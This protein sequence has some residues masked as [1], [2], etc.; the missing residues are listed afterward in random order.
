MSEIC[1]K[2]GLPKELCMC[3]EIAREQQSVRIS[4]DSRRYGKT[5][6]VIDG[7][8]GNDIDIADL[9]KTLKSRCAAGGTCKDGR[10]ELQGDHKKKV[11][12]VLEEIGFRTEVR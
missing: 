6:T 2:C 8:D 10:I 11:K 3:E 7:I 1:P 5:V 12:A 4:I 9:A